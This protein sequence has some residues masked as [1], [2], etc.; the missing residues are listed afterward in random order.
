MRRIA[1]AIYSPVEHGGR[2][3]A[4]SRG[5]ER[6][7]ARVLLDKLCY[8]VDNPGYRYK[9]STACGIGNE[10]VPLDNRELGE[11]NAP[12]E[13]GSFLVDFL[14]KLL[15]AALFDLVGSE[16]LE[17]R[18]QSELFPGPDRPFG[19]VILPPFDRVAVIRGEL[20]S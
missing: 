16:L 6:L 2:V 17:V 13:R 3:L 9:P 20:S 14:L 4:N 12:V 5:Y 15:D 1:V 8:V 18:G 7:P 11:R 19:R 10:I